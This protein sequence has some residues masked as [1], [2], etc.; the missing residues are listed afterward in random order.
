MF[1][2]TANTMDSIP[3]PLLDRME[4]IKL[5]GYTMDEKLN[6]ANVHLVPKQIEAHGLNSCALELSD[7]VLLHII[8]RYTHES[9]VR[10][11]DRAIASVC[12]YKCREYADL[13]EA[14]GLDSFKQCIDVHDLEAILGVCIIH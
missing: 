3:P 5:G 6:I 8:E 2:A 12:R 10:S 1:I 7:K 4:V 13:E 9:G 14:N 11:L